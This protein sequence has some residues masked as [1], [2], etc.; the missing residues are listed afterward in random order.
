VEDD[1]SVAPAPLHPNLSDGGKISR[2][3][4]ATGQVQDVSPEPVRMGKYRWVRT[5]PVLFSPVDPRVLYL[6]ATVLFKTTN[7]GASW[8]T[9]SPD[10]TPA[11]YDVPPALRAFTTLHPAQG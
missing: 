4:W 8:Q 9:I 7:G 5:M 1:G 2:F 10:L 3:D 6:G 11:M